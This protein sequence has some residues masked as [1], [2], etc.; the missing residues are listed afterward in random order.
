MIQQSRLEVLGRT[1][2]AALAAAPESPLYCFDTDRLLERV[3]WVRRALGSEID[4]CFAVKANPF[5][6]EVLSPAVDCFE[7]CSPGEYEICRAAGVKPEQVVLSGVY[8]SPA[9]I[10]ETA[11]RAPGM[12][13]FTVESQQQWALLTQA[14][15][16]RTEPIRL[17]LRLTS[18]NQFGLDESAVEAIVADRAAH[19]MIEIA[20]IQFFSGTQKT[21]LKRLR[22]EV[23]LLDRVIQNLSERYGFAVRELEYGPGLPVQYFQDEKP[24]DEAA[25]AAEFAAM[26]AGM[27]YTGHKTLEYGRFLTADCGFYVTRVVDMKINKGQPYLI[28]D[29]GMHHLTYYGQSMAMR[30][31]YMAHLCA[32]DGRLEAID[33][34][35]AQADTAPAASAAPA[36]DAGTASAGQTAVC[37]AVAGETVPWCVCGSLCT[38][39]D[40]LAKQLPVRNAQIGDYLIFDRTGA[41]GSTEGISLFLSRDLPAVVLYST[42]GGAAV[43]RGHEPTHP[44]NRR[45]N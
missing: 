18:G 42:S 36:A 16:E 17:L 10:A 20:G 44:F 4:V 15:A 45:R 6:V 40:I 3:A 2:S 21:S 13:A 7:V 41:Y 30:V 1:A 26:L 34:R 31:P 43:L 28:V 8:K 11:R 32:S 39:N 9:D 24:F 29:G 22:R 33:A 19:P 5:L 37:P 25:F 14:A 23:E 38:I 27:R 35:P 12:R